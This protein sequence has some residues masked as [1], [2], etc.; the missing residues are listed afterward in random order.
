MAF[1]LIGII[2]AIGS[3]L[4]S[5]VP[6]GDMLKNRKA[7]KS[8]QRLAEMIAEDLADKNFPGDKKKKKVIIKLAGEMAAD[9]FYQGKFNQDDWIRGQYHEFLLEMAE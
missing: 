8:C 6:I 4:G 9:Q 3:A 1:P 7:R 2:G 5:I